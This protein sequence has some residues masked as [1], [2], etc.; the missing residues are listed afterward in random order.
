M[1]DP[2]TLQNQ[3]CFP[4]YVASKEVIKRYKPLLDKL[5]LTYT[6]YITMMVLWEKEKINVKSLGDI[7]FLD[8]GTLTPLLKK[9]ESK[10]YI[11]RIRDSKDER[12]LIIS[13]TNEGKKLKEEAKDVPKCLAACLNF[14]EEDAK[15]LYR[16]LYK[17]LGRMDKDV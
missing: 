12:N 8:S 11:K 10:N 16:L 1:N 6:Q 14:K 9:L 15:E 4:L 17:L 7:L 3:L 5:D 13:I 2:L